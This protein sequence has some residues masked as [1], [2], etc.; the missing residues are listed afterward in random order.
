MIGRTL[1]TLAAAVLACAAACNS[2]A[3]ADAGPA[4]AHLAASVS[5]PTTP[6]FPPIRRVHQNGT[7]PAPRLTNG[8]PTVPAS[9]IVAHWWVDPANSTGCASDRNNCVSA[10]CGGAGV[11]P[12]L[13]YSQIVSRWG[14]DGPRLPQTTTITLLSNQS[15]GVDPITFSGTLLNGS[16]LIFTGPLTHLPGPGAGAPTTMV[17]DQTKNRTL[18]ATGAPGG[19]LLQVTFNAPV[20]PGVLVE[21]TTAGKSSRAFVYSVTGGNVAVMTQPIASP[22]APLTAPFTPAEVDTWATGDSVAGV[23]LVSVNVAAIHASGGQQSSS[24]FPLTGAMVQLVGLHVLDLSGTPG[25]SG[26]SP[27]DTDSAVILSDSWVEPVLQQG[28]TSFDI[29]T[30]VE[31]ADCYCAG[32]AFLGVEADFY[33]GAVPPSAADSLALGPGSAVDGD[34]IAG[35]GLFTLGTPALVATVAIPPGQSAFVD[36]NGAIYLET[37]FTGANAM[38][39]NFTL[40]FFGGAGIFLSSSGVPT[41]ASTLFTSSITGL[42]TPST[43]TSGTPGTWNNFVGAITPAGIDAAPGHAVVDPLERITL[44]MSL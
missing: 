27:S 4:P 5:Q 13:D 42:R 1:A 43:Y 34:A 15:L 38:W 37:L 25:S 39:G 7:V 6:R 16:N 14:T 29:Q 8:G 22:G 23:Q 30:S 32:G 40:S 44:S 10:T 19:G 33:A 21:N 31:V 3:G 26:L 20:T 24:A 18:P 28:T 9:W 35:G 36:P 11:G 41:W 17:L 12:C 2:G